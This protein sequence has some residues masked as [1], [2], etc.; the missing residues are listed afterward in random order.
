MVDKNSSFDVNA[1]VDGNEDRGATRKDL[2]QELE[3][4]GGPIEPH[5]GELANTPASSGGSPAPR[6]ESHDY[7]GSSKGAR[8]DDNYERQTDAEAR[9]KTG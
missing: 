9:E 5:S 4:T 7:E 3:E 2:A 6:G 1:T 8:T